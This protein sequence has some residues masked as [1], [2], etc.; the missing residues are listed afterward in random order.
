MPRRRTAICIFADGHAVWEGLFVG[1]HI[2]EF[3]GV[4]ATNKDVRIPLLVVYDVE[5][6][7]INRARVYFMMSSF[8][9]QVGDQ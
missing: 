6:D 1:K 7:Q 5:N 2:G 4:P 8:F 9:A 3:A